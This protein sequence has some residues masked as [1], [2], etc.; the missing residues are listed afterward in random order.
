MLELLAEQLA[1]VEA[2][3]LG[4]TSQEVTKLMLVVLRERAALAV[5]RATLDSLFR[6]LAQEDRRQHLTPGQIQWLTAEWL[7]H[8]LTSASA[9]G[10]TEPPI[11]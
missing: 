1:K 6:K 7:K 10:T 8:G 4:M 5:P 11:T 9:A 3:T 2:P